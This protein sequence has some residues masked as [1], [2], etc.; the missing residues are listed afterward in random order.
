LKERSTEQVLNELAGLLQLLPLFIFFAFQSCNHRA[1]QQIEAEIADKLQAT[2]PMIKESFAPPKITYI[3]TSNQPKKVPA[4]NPNVRLVSSNAG[5]PVFKNYGREQGFDQI[6]VFTGTADRSGALWFGT[7]YG[8]IRYNGKTFTN[9]T[10]HQGLAIPPVVCIIQDKAGNLWIGTDNEGVIFYD[11]KQFSNIDTK[12]GLP[13]NSV[14][15]MIQDK[16]GN[17]W[18]AT[19]GG[20]VSKYDGKRFENMGTAD[21]LASDTVA[22]I[23]EDSQ[24]NIW[25]GT[26]GGGVSKYDGK[27]F[28]NYSILQ[29]FAGKYVKSIFEDKSGNMWFG[30]EDGGVSEYDG[31]VFKNFTTNQGLASNNIRCI[32]QDDAGNLWFGT[33]DGGVSIFDGEVFVNYNSS[34]GMTNN[35]V[36][37]ILKDRYGSLWLCTSGGGLSR[38]MNNITNY[39]SLFGHAGH[40]ITSMIRDRT[41]NL[42]FGVTSGGISKYDGKTI[43]NYNRTRG[44]KSDVVWSMMQ[45]NAGDIWI[46][47]DAGVSE[48]DGKDFTNY[49]TDQGLPNSSV[50]C[51]LQDKA[52]NIWF[53]TFKGISKYDGKSF[54]SYSKD[55]GLAND[56]VSSIMQD[57]EGNIWVG[58]ENWASKFDGKKF[59]NYLLAHN[60]EIKPIFE[61]FDG[62]ICFSIQGG[63]GIFKYDGKHFSNFRIDPELKWNDVNATLKDSIKKVLWLGTD[64]G[65]FGMKEVFDSNGEKLK[66]G[67]DVFYVDADYLSDGLQA[68]CLDNNDMLWMGGLGNRVIK[69]D[70]SANPNFLTPLSI[71]IQS[72][73]INDQNICWNNLPGKLQVNNETDSLIL[74]NEMISTFG[75][76]LP[77]VELDGMRIKFSG[78]EFDNVT[79]Y[80]P[81]PLNLVL[82]YKDNSISFDFVAIE[83]ALPKQVKYQYKLEGFDKDWS[84][85]GNSTTAVFGNLNEGNYTFRLKALSPYGVW[86]EMEY[87][88]KVLPPWY[89]TWWAYI[90]YAIVLIGAMWSFIYYRSQQLRRENR[91]LEEKVNLRTHQLKEE[92]EKVESTLSELKSTQAKLIQSEKMA[93]LGELTAGIA[94]EIQN[95]LNFVNNFSEVNTELI[96]ELAQEANKGNI[97]EVKAIANDIKENEQKINHH[98]KRADAIVKGMLQHSRTSTGV[99]E[100]TD[101]NALADEYLR[102]SYHGLR[103]KDKNFYAEMKTDF[104]GSLGKVNIIPQDIGRVLLN[105]YNNA[106]YALNEKKKSAGEGYEPTVS[107]STKKIDNKIIISVKDNGNGIPQKVLDKI[108]QP[109]F[110]TKPTGVGTGLGL[111]LSYDIVKAHGGDIKVETKEGAGS[112]FVVQ[113]LAS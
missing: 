87:K 34:D 108:F 18:F 85:L 78:I 92:K 13:N 43:T 46:G 50:T 107:L 8:V 56:T 55:Q 110:T 53:G 51:I 89:R 84:L 77:Q 26:L 38:V 105:L 29:G 100:S 70:Y 72:I 112:E 73:K 104:D 23:L 20:G 57:K 40:F 16:A 67:V 5:A 14:L 15:S 66:N 49:T 12:D 36:N 75:Y 63:E 97:E 86:S 10:T 65:L 7:P 54:I 64:F 35:N 19:G 109:F 22:S 90:L 52:G 45:D 62:N 21:G 3:T 81:V 47:T 31:S 37:C 96:D 76:I 42:W 1:G 59:T 91:L 32:N 25:M 103:A 60:G 95:P 82:P 80:Y 71:N 83:P 27:G 11:G 58:T 111:S 102:L 2:I 98:G 69:L 9:F 94:H 48:F 79:P 44:L 6:V 4:G 93:S 41:G 61:D 68:L 74:I 113:L 30:T 101:I 39:S 17:L 99:K 28:K 88:F 33:Y 24:G 106:F